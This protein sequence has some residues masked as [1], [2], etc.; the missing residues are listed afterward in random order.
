MAPK[1][2]PAP[3]RVSGTN[4]VSEETSMPNL[5]QTLKAYF[6]KVIGPT[7]GCTGTGCTYKFNIQTDCYDLQSMSCGNCSCASNICGFEALVIAAIHPES[8][9][10]ALAGTAIAIPFPCTANQQFKETYKTIL[11]SLLK[12]LVDDVVF[13]RRVSIGLAVMSALLAVGLVYA[14]FFR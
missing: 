5:D 6:A 14:L 9:A 4:P 7:A 8:V 1:A 10:S 13:W 11:T 12:H 2:F 3:R